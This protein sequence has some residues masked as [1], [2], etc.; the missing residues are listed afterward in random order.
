VVLK[1]HVLSIVWAIIIALLTLTS[2]GMNV[3][4]EFENVDKVAH[5]FTL[6]V[7][8]FLLIVGFKKHCNYVLHLDARY[9]SVIVAILY[10]VIIE[11]IQVFVP[12]RQFELMDIVAN[13][14]GSVFGMLLFY[15]VYV[16]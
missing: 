16:L 10:G 2:G 5:A 11:F 12:G 15:I 14:V 4:L 13:S 1:Y 9:F 3:D 6:L 7:F 8:S